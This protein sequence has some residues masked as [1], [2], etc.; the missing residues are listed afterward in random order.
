MNKEQIEKERERIRDYTLEFVAD[1]L[2]HKDIMTLTHII[3]NQA[4]KQ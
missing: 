4:I 3:E 2:S 1:K